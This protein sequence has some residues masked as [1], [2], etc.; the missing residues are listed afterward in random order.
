MFLHHLSELNS[1]GICFCCENLFT[2]ILGHTSANSTKSV[3]IFILPILWIKPLSKYWP[4]FKNASAL[5]TMELTS[6]LTCQQKSAGSHVKLGEESA[7]ATLVL[8]LLP[9][10]LSQTAT[11]NQ[12][13]VPCL[14]A[15]APQLSLTHLAQPATHPWGVD[16]KPLE[17]LLTDRRGTAA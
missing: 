13:R 14:S 4:W 6:G 10:C 16:K 9:S 5:E 3:Q 15:T 12:L 17:T 8:S 2:W 11:F 7:A 1:V